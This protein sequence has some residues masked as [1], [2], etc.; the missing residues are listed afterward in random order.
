MCILSW[1]DASVKWVRGKLG[2]ITVRIVPSEKNEKIVRV[3]SRT[4]KTR[5]KKKP[6]SL[7]TTLIQGHPQLHSHY[8]LPATNPQRFLPYGILTS[9]D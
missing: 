8:P 3:Q 4:H 5:E 2:T 7:Q 9:P 6:F 1:T